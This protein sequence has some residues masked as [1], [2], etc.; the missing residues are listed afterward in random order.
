[1]VPD[2]YHLTRFVQIHPTQAV[3]EK[4]LLGLSEGEY[5][6]IWMP[7]LFPQHKS[8]SVGQRTRYFSIQ[9]IH[10]ARA[11]LTHEFLGGRLIRGVH[12]A[13]HGSGE[14]ASSVFSVNDAKRFHACV[15]LFMNVSDD[16]VFYDVIDQWYLGYA[17][18]ETT[19]ILGEY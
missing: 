8:L 5:K 19:D 2:P 18:E 13:L 3:F 4:I 9:D 1:M 15:T 14:N 17:H 16:P 7:Y 6:H 11:F 12:A 10:E